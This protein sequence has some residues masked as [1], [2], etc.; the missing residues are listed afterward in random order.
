MLSR[1]TKATGSSVTFAAALLGAA[2][3]LS[4]VFGIAR[5]RLL[6]GTF[7]AGPELDAYYAAF[8]VP[9]LVYNLFVVGA[10]S[11]GFIPVFMSYMTSKDGDEAANAFAAKVLSVI[12]TALAALAIVGIA[13][14]QHTVPWITSGFDAEQR[15]LTIQLSRIMFLSPFFLGLSSV[16]GAV[17]QSR[18]RFLVYAI[19]PVLYNVG[20]I[21]G[22][23]LLSPRFGIAGVA[24]GVVLGSF[25]HFIIQAV[26]AGRVG[27][28]FRYRPD[29]RD[30][31]VREMLRIMVPRTAGLAMTQVN[32]LILTGVA[33]TIG[34]GSVAVF[35][36]ATNLQSFP[37]GVL[38]VSFAVA[39]FPLISELAARG[40]T[41]R[42]R[43]EFSGTVRTILFLIIPAAVAFLLL[44]AQIVRVILGTGAFDWGDTIDTADTLAYF[45]LSLFAQ[46]LI[47]FLVRMFFALKDVMTP[48]IAVGLSVVIERVLAVKLVAMGMGT[49]ALA[50]AFSVGE[51]FQIAG[52]W[53]ILR[54]R[55]GSLDESRVFK[56]LAVISASAFAM[57]LAM[58]GTKILLGPWVETRTFLGIFGQGVVAG[59][60]G[61]A[62]YA[63][64]ALFLGSEEAR[65]VVSYAK[66]RV[67]RV[68]AQIVQEDGGLTVE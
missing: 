33:T 40:D 45:T 49:P 66:R 62:T 61:V 20:I 63:G 55:M 22:I 28:R 26:D 27:F 64:V 67:S 47:P 60:I 21:A 43:E 41:A 44:R 17:L 13:T 56:S 48:L 10:V 23:L 25:L 53:I 11:A 65:K 31:G 14:A 38:G 32:L 15:A 3:L 50:L 30:R 42:L 9:D 12:G 51:I 68:P 54:L 6:S 58:Q 4:R 1:I 46:A 36:L 52:L 16:I 8:R 29:V 19:A 2:S 34:A 7:G 24:A 37:V 39:S 59:L 5:D 18:R 35:N 57:G